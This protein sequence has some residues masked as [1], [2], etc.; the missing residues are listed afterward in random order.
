ML[1]AEKTLIHT[2]ATHV[3]L[4]YDFTD[5]DGWVENGSTDG[6]VFTTLKRPFLINRTRNRVIFFFCNLP[7]NR[8]RD[9]S[10]VQFFFNGY[11]ILVNED[12]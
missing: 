11:N 2:F 3:G 9:D 6:R 12:L 5:T 4:T 10:S 8:T 1:L 7:L